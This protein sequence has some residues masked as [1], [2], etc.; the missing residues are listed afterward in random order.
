MYHFTNYSDLFRLEE[1]LEYLRK[2]QSDDP[3]LTVEEVLQKHETILDEWSEKH[4]GAKVPE[5]NKFREVVSGETIKERPEINKLLRLI[6]SPKYK[7]VKVVEPQRLTRGDLE[8]I[9]RLMKL[10]KHTN[11][12]VITPDRMYDLRDEYDWNAF[13]AELKRGNDYLNYYKKIQN[14]GRLLSVSQGNYLGSIPPYGFDKTVVMDGKRK[15]PTLKENKAEA[16]IVRLI[17]D[18]YVNKDMGCTRICNYLDEMKIKPPKGEHWSP[19]A[20]KDKLANVHYIGKVKWNWRKTIDIVEDGEFIKTRPKAK[21][22]EYLIYEGR[23]NGIVSEELFNA[24]QEKQGRNHRAKPTTKVRNPL[25]GLLWCKCGRAMSL[26]FFKHKDGTEK[27][28]P[29]LSCEGQKFCNNGSCL[30]EEIISR[31]VEVLEQCIED[32]E[33]RIVNDTGDSIK[34]H[35]QLIKNLEKKM[36]EIQARELTQWEQQSHP[37]P[38]QRMPAEIFKQLNEKLLHEKEEVQQA[39]CKA[40]ESMPEPVDYEEKLSRFK[41]ALAAL[42]DPEA[43]AALQNSLLKA[44]I[45]RIEYQR[46]RPERLKK[47]PGEKKGTRFTSVGGRWTNPPIYLD[48]KLKV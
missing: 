31:V 20:M 25:A 43:D 33:I 17:F 28:A 22:G 35:N 45:D 29:R 11:T 40:Y 9:G 6:E 7:A 8:D 44:C 41:D 34:L 26:R 39:L 42:K 1:I 14:R 12:Y 19:A 18:L 46:E 2:S 10:L 24:A 15:C 32:F 3:L 4:F 38:A 47:E 23:H 5:Q 36:K 27:S 37:D 13:E 30:Y 16:D 21:I 48:I